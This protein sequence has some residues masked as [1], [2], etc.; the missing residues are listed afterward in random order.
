MPATVKITGNTYP[1]RDQLARLG[2]RWSA[3]ERCWYV[4]EDRA[5]EAKALIAQCGR[6][7]PKTTGYRR[8]CRTCG[9]RINY[10]VYCGMCEF[11]R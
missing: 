10:G 9:C 4:S 8:T 5:D 6:A 2:A 7:T 3:S 11:G 1:V